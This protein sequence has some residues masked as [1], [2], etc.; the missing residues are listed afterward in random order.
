[1]VAGVFRGGEADREAR[2]NTRA[3]GGG[4]IPNG[5]SKDGLAVPSDPRNLLCFYA[6]F[7]RGATLGPRHRYSVVLETSTAPHTS[8]I[9]ISRSRVSFEA[10]TILL[11]FIDSLHP[12]LFRSF[13]LRLDVPDSHAAIFPETLP[14]VYIG[15]SQSGPCIETSQGRS[16]TPYRDRSTASQYRALSSP[17]AGCHTRVPVGTSGSVPVVRLRGYAR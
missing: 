1:L 4:S 14:F 11:L 12:P 5:V 17:P 8:E 16:G 13:L 6:I 9:G 15:T 2:Q 7:V 3:R 10:E